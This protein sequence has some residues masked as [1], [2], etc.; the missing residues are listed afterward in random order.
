ML[1][2]GREVADVCV[3]T[4]LGLLPRRVSKAGQ[5]STDALPRAHR[6]QPHAHE[7]QPLT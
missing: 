6:T 1:L 3:L 7:T 2:T 5:R 4:A